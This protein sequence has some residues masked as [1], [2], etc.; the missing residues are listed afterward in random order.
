MGF[1]AWHATASKELF[2]FSSHSPAPTDD[3]WLRSTKK[4]DSRDSLRLYLSTS[5]IYLKHHRL[6]L[7]K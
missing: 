4:E 1:S 5:N 2:W 7:R 6:F 3:V